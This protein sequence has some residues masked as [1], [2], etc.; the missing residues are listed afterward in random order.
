MTDRLT[1]ILIATGLPE[2]FILSGLVLFLIG[3]GF[4]AGRMYEYLSGHSAKPTKPVA[5]LA[6]VI[7]LA[8]YFFIGLSLMK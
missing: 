8:L 5:M 1:E 7:V 2:W 4:V 3:N 6:I